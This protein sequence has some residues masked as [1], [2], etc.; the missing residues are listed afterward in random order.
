MLSPPSLPSPARGEG[1]EGP[2]R[3]GEKRE[4][5]GP[6]GYQVTPVSPSRQIQPVVWLVPTAHCGIAVHYRIEVNVSPFRLAVSEY[7]GAT[8]FVE[9]QAEVMHDS[10]VFVQRRCGSRRSVWQGEWR[11]TDIDRAPAPPVLTYLA[12]PFVIDKRG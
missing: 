12:I 9:Q 11:T 8:H 3:Q 10:G 4:L 1:V 7:S 6:E 5:N 2:G